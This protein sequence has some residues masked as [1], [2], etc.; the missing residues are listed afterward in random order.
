M[1]PQDVAFNDFALNLHKGFSGCKLS[2]DSICF[3]QIGAKYEDNLF[4]ILTGFK[5]DREALLTYE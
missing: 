3:I 1:I 2:L 4:D 5:K